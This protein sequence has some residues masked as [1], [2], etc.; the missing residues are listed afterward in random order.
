MGLFRVEDRMNRRW[1]NRVDIL[2]ANLKAARRFAKRTVEIR[3]VER[4]QTASLESGWPTPF[5]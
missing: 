2:H 4:S 3:W 5:G 1:E